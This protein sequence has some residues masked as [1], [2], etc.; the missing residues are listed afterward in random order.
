[1]V[2]VAGGAFRMWGLDYG[3]FSED[4]VNKVRAVRAY[5]GGDIG[6][7]AEHPMVMKTAMLL[8]LSAAH[9]WN[10]VAESGGG[11]PRVSEEAALR[12]PNALGGSAAV[13]A[14]F[15][16]ARSFFGP[17]TAVAAG[18][19]LALDVTVTGI[20][21][22]GK[23][24]TFLVLFLLLGAWL[25]EEARG[26]HARTGR[27]PHAWYAASGAAF[28]LMLA[29]KYMPFYAGFWAIFLVA[30]TAEDRKSGVEPPRTAVSA[31]FYAAGVVAFLAANPA[32]LLPGTWRYLA[33]YA[34][35][36]TISHHG[37][38]F[39]GR[40]YMNMLGAT[41][42][43]LPWCFYLAYIGAKTPLPVLAVAGVG[44]I[45]LVRRRRQRGAVFAR[46]FLLFFLLPFS[47]LA[48]KF[49]RYLLPTLVVLDMVA[50][51]GVV[52]VFDLVSGIGRPWLRAL[53]AGAVA[54]AVIGAP[55]V[56]QARWSPHPSLYL[57]EVASRIAGP[58]ELFPNDELYDMGMRESV[59]WI[60]A[61]AARGA[62]I[63]S[64]APGV[65]AEYLARAGRGDVEARSLSMQGLATPPVETW[66]LAQ[67][68][69]A[70]FES[71]QLV[72]QVRRRQQPDF[73]YRVRGTA[74]VETFRLP[75]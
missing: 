48:S 9:A 56:A 64:D 43:G 27:P 30:A 12:L 36:Q 57:N 20:N 29:S 39:A 69:H 15:L 40:V 21:R 35:G 71:Q 61:R 25:Y 44:L 73:V 38:Y 45:E 18:G 65:V 75:W 49:A 7:N 31:S 53:A 28:G 24:D 11:L 46:V 23:E 54:A 14:L 17:A 62:S 37:A 6:A 58:G 22:I 55:L 33:G 42:A 32:I 34:Q 47:L 60:A 16:L 66:L 19:L 1:V 10:V 74:A 50:A 63:A 52:R 3:G 13:V 26:R 4:E 70:C 8:S 51:L 59:E 2:V 72:A 68:S 67:N 5:A 41:P